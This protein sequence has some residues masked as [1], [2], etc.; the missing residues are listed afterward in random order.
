MARENNIR[1]EAFPQDTVVGGSEYTVS[2]RVTNLSESLMS[3]LI[4]LPS[5]AA[6]IEIGQKTESAE[7]EVNDLENKK[8]KL[9]RELEKQVH[10][11][12][13]RNRRRTMSIAERIAF[14]YAEAIEMYASLFTR[15][16]SVTVIPFWAVE[17]LKIDNW[18]DVVRLENDI[19]SFEQDDS[20]LKKAFSINKDKL[21][22]VLSKLDQ[23]EEQDTFKKGIDLHAG[24]SISFPFVF[25]AP[26]LFKLKKFNIQFSIYFKRDK[27][28]VSKQINTS[29][30]SD[31][32]I[33]PSPF[34]VP[35]GGM[36]GAL[37]GYLIRFTLM[38]NQTENLS[39]V[40]SLDYRYI[41]GSVLLGLVVTLFTA[42]KPNTTKAITTED[43]LGGFILGA[44]V[45][46]FSEVFIEKMAALIK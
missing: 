25:K 42:R 27:G 21:E 18:E 9:I 24:E 45:G 23:K 28:E 38:T 31:L 41:I 43:F 16:S 36:L 35:T 26:H 30:E 46:M 22:N 5:L 20:F 15:R 6:G 14:S 10:S 3:D 39:I 44:L 13:G 7:T 19:I 2:V 8:R 33:S 12:Y 11:A 29:C 32:V 34:A 40:D 4:V 17:A 37:S 1:I